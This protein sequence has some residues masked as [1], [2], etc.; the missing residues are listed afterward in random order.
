MRRTAAVLV[1]FLVVGVAPALG[2]TDP[3]DANWYVNG[4]LNYGGWTTDPPAITAEDVTTFSPTDPRLGANVGNNGTTS[5]GMHWSYDEDGPYHGGDN[6]RALLNVDIP[7]PVGQYNIE[8]SLDILVNWDPVAQPWG[9]GQEW[10]IGDASA[11]D[12]GAW[13]GDGAPSGPWQGANWGN[14]NGTKLGSQWNG[15]SGLP[16]AYNGIW[17]NKVFTSEVDAGETVISAASG[18]VT[19]R[20]VG[21]W[22]VANAPGEFMSIAMDNL[23]VTLTD[24]NSGIQYCYNDAFLPEPSTALLLGLGLPLLMRRRR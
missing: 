24:V 17:Y 3:W 6:G 18:V 16:E 7:M 20:Q 1:C 13:A 14:D 12:Y 5:G 22:K 10:Y 4:D 8:V 11:M 23:T 9:L 15:T 2:G 19:F 21:R